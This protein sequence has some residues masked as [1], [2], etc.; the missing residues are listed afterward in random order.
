PSRAPL[1]V[2][3]WGKAQGTAERFVQTAQERR[4]VGPS[5]MLWGNDL[6]QGGWAS[7]GTT[8][9]GW[10]THRHWT[11]SASAITRDAMGL[12]HPV[13]GYLAGTG[14]CDGGWVCRAFQ[15]AEDLANDLTLRDDGD[16]SQ[17]PTLTQWTR[18]HLQGKHVLQ[19]PG[20]GPIWGTPL[21]LLH[22]H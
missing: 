15:M 20:Q 6:G 4:G 10:E 5:E 17:Y 3:P 16:K 11:H 22:V 7:R 13:T 1:L 19:E 8:P 12:G 18:A 2:V 21:C 9:Q 14:W